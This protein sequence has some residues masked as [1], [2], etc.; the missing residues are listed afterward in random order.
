MEQNNRLERRKTKILMNSDKI[1]SQRLMMRRKSRAKGGLRP[2]ES[3]PVRD[4][5]SFVLDQSSELADNTNIPLAI[6]RLRKAVAYFVNVLAVVLAAAI[7]C[8]TIPAVQDQTK[9]NTGIFFFVICFCVIV[10]SGDWILRFGCSTAKKKFLRNP[11]N[12]FDI[13]SLLP[14]WADVAGVIPNG[15]AQWILILRITRIIRQF[16]AMESF[17]IIHKTLIQSTE[18]ITIYVMISLIALPLIGCA[19]FMAE[20]GAQNSLTGKWVRNCTIYQD[21]ALEDSPF[22]SGIDGMWFAMNLMTTLGY[23]DIYPTSSGGKAIAAFGM[24]LGLF[25]LAYPAMIM[26]VNFSAE[27]EVAE[28]AA[29]L[30]AARS[31]MGIRQTQRNLTKVVDKEMMKVRGRGSMVVANG[32][33]MMPFHLPPLFFYC[34][35]DETYR[36]AYLLATTDARHEPLFRVKRDKDGLIV[37]EQHKLK[38]PEFRFFII[39][40]TSEASTECTRAITALLPADAPAIQRCR[41]EHV[42]TVHFALEVPPDNGIILPNLRLMRSFDDQIEPT[43]QIVHGTI[44]V[45]NYHRTMEDEDVYELISNLSRCRLHITADV[46]QAEPT[47]YDVPFFQDTLQVTNLCSALL[48]H[49]KGLVYCTEKE[50]AA[51]LTDVPSLISLPACEED[52]EVVIINQ[53][54]II[55]TVAKAVVRNCAIEDEPNFDDPTNF[56]HEGAQEHVDGKPMKYYGVV[57]YKVTGVKE[58][59]VYLESLLTAIAEIFTVVEKKAADVV[60]SKVLCTL[61]VKAVRCKQVHKTVQL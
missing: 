44:E 50:I 13:I 45:Q 60:E 15:I 39:L 56:M 10:F 27:V 54:E 51:L 49:K 48:G 57:G 53:T 61:L 37:L 16:L 3:I 20:R 14:F 29:M 26:S 21:C 28:K 58:R 8:Q 2:W 52:E 32:A 5:I 25:C 4:R 46:A 19:M 43:R 59:G 33:L 12:V 42:P 47:V 11:L 40:T 38:K 9:N 36:R 7:I 23:G 31:Q 35:E 30:R 6:L 41:N 18:A 17:E 55:A 1:E 34:K 24:L 22:Q